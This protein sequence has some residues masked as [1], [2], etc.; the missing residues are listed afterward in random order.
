MEDNTVPSAS[1]LGRSIW[2]KLMMCSH[3]QPCTSSSTQPYRDGETIAIHDTQHMFQ[4]YTPKYQDLD[5]WKAYLAE[6]YANGTPFTVD[7]IMP[8][9]IITPLTDEEVIALLS[10]KSFDEITH[11]T[12]DSTLKPIISAEYGTSHV[13]AIAL[14]AWN[15]AKRNEI[16]NAKLVELT[17]SIATALV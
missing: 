15:T 1:D 3:M 13:G 9:P 14:D 4:L 8:T 11:V 12:T 6:Q 16:K 5:S 10:M 17:N 2:S 7:V